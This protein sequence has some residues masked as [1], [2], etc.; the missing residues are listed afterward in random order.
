[1]GHAKDLL[2]PAVVGFFSKLALEITDLA[3]QLAQS[4]IGGVAAGLVLGGYV[5]SK[6]LKGC[7]TKG[8]VPGM[9][10]QRGSALRLGRML[11]TICRRGL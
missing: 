6:K 2:R 7:S 3:I 9:I 1:M 10:L 11:Y 8:Y 4:E 5:D